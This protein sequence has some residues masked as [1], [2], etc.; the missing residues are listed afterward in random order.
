MR[1]QIQEQSHLFL[2]SPPLKYPSYY[3]QNPALSNTPV[4]LEFVPKLYHCNAGAVSENISRW[5]FYGTYA[6][7]TW[8]DRWLLERFFLNFAFRKNG[9]W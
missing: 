2:F 7:L 4:A 5:F 9:G 3:S 1:T 8:T 6:A